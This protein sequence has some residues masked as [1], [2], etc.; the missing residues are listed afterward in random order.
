MRLDV[1]ELGVGCRGNCRERSDLVQKCRLELVGRH[2]E[3][4][5]AEANKVRIARVR[6]DPHPGLPSQADGA[7]HHQGV[8]RVEATRDV[9]GAYE[10]DQ[11]LVVAEVP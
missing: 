4:S 9:D 1:L 11:R 10:G 2:V 7:D 6:P 5:T 8:A 3:V